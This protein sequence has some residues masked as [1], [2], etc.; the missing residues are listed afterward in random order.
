MPSVGRRIVL[1]ACS[2]NTPGVILFS[3]WHALQKHLI[4]P[5]SENTPRSGSLQ[6]RYSTSRPSSSPD[7]KMRRS[8]QR[9][10]PDSR[11][12]SCICAN[13][14]GGTCAMFPVAY[15]RRGGYAGPTSSAPNAAVRAMAASAA[16]RRGRPGVGCV[17][18]RAAALS[19]ASCAKLFG[20]GGASAAAT[21][22]VG[23]PG[24]APLAAGGFFWPGE[25]LYSPIISR[26]CLT[27]YMAV[28]AAE[29]LLLLRSIWP[30]AA[31]GFHPSSSECMSWPLERALSMLFPGA[32]TRPWARSLRASPSYSC[33]V[34]LSPSS[35]AAFLAGGGMAGATPSW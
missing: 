20:A 11:N 1:L 23:V 2:S 21:A 15:A 29:R 25:K 7:L 8:P 31:A 32:I 17:A 30:A 3:P 10:S 26:A 22:G 27:P 24:I 35:S 19:A 6:V 13:M 18:S 12:I 4:R 14:S 5:V 28:T 33:T 9:L 34:F 16:A